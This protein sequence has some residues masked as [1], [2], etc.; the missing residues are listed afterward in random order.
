MCRIQR[1]EFLLREEEANGSTSSSRPPLASQTPDNPA[2]ASVEFE[3]HWRAQELRRLAQEGIPDDPV[4]IRPSTYRRL[5]NLSNTATLASDYSS[6][7]SEVESTISSL[8]P[9]ELHQPLHRYD[10]L[11]REIERDVERTFGALSWF[12]VEPTLTD[13]DEDGRED[14]LW[15]RLRALDEMDTRIAEELS[16]KGVGRGETPIQ[17][18]SDEP[19]TT[20]L[21]S[22]SPPP[23]LTLNIPSSL[24]TTAVDIPP[25]PNTPTA[26]PQSFSSTPSHS[27]RRPS[28]RR[29]ALLRPLFVYAFLNPGVSYVQ[30]MSYLVAVFYYIF[31]SDPT[32]S[33]RQ[34]EATT[35]FAFGSL[36]S[37]L[38]DLY[39]PT[40]DTIGRETSLTHGLG[41]TIERFQGL[42]L[43]LDPTLADTL[44]RK[45]VDLG[46]V[47]LRWLTT[48]FANEFMLPDLVRIW[49][50]IISVYPRDEQQPESLSPMLSHVL[51]LAL[52][53]VI[54][55]RSTFLSPYT[56]LSK[57]YALLQ[58]PSI[59]GSA[60]DK[61]LLLAWDIR[62]RRAGRQSSSTPKPESS[63]PLKRVGSLSQSAGLLKQK[64]WSPASTASRPSQANDFELDTTSSSTTESRLSGRPASRQGGGGGGAFG[65]LAFS[66]PR[67]SAGSLANNVTMIEGKLLPPPPARMEER[68]TIASIVEAELETPEYGLDDDDEDSD[69]RKGTVSSLGGWFKNSMSRIASSDKAAN[70]SKRA[71]NLQLAAA[72]SASTTASRLQSSDAAAQLLKAQ[73]NLAIQAQL[74][75]ERVAAEQFAN[76]V[77]DAGERLMASTGSERG[78][79]DDFG[80][81][82][83]PFTPPVGGMRSPSPSN[84]P[85]GSNAPRPL[86]LSSSARRAHNGSIDDTSD[87]PLS[88]RRSSMAGSV[89]SPSTSPVLSR[90]THL[91]L[92]SPDLSIPPLSRS[93][94]R[95]S[96]GRSTSTFDTPTRTVPASDFRPRS[97]SQSLASALDSSF[98]EDVPIVSTR[99][100]SPATARLVGEEQRSSKEENVS[101]RSG[102]GW[103][104]SDAPRGIVRHEDTK[105]QSLENGLS[106][107]AIEI[108]PTENTDA[109]L[110][111]PRG[112]SLEGNGP[113][114]S[115]FPLNTPARLDESLPIDGPSETP[116]VP[117]SSEPF[118]APPAPSTNSYDNTLPPDS[119]STRRTTSPPPPLPSSQPSLSRGAKI[120]RRPAASKKRSS[121]GSSMAASMDFETSNTM[122][123]DESGIT[124]ESLSRS[125]VPVVE[126]LET[127]GYS[128]SL[129]PRIDQSPFHTNPAV[130]SGTD[131]TGGSRNASDS[132]GEMTTGGQEDPRRRS[133]SGRGKRSDKDTRGTAGQPEADHIAPLKIPVSTTKK[134]S[135]TLDDL[136]DIVKS[137]RLYATSSRTNDEGETRNSRTNRETSTAN[138]NQSENVTPVKRRGPE[139]STPSLSPSP[140]PTSPASSLA[141]S[142]TRRYSSPT[143]R[144]RHATSSASLLSLFIASTAASSLLKTC[145]SLVQLSPTLSLLDLLQLSQSLQE[146]A[147]MLAIAQGQAVASG[148]TFGSSFDTLARLVASPGEGKSRDPS[149]S[150]LLAAKALNL[151]SPSEENALPL[152]RPSTPSPPLLILTTPRTHCRQCQSP[153]TIRSKPN[154]PFSLVSPSEPPRPIL[155]ACHVCTNAACR[156]RHSADHVEITHEKHKVWIWEEEASYTKVGDRVWVSSSFSKHFKALLL[157]QRVSPGGFADVWN[158]QHSQGAN[159]E[160]GLDSE[161]AVGEQ[162]EEDLE[163]ENEPNSTGGVFKLTPAHVW[164]S[165]VIS[166]SLEAAQIRGH[167]LLSTARPSSETL[168]IRQD[169]DSDPQEKITFGVCDGISIGHFLCA[170]PSCSNPPIKQTRSQRF[171]KSHVKSHELCGVIGCNKSISTFPDPRSEACDDP[172]HLAA[173]KMFSEK[174][175]AVTRRGWRGFRPNEKTRDEELSGEEG[176]GTEQYPKSQIKNTWSLRRVAKL[177][178]LVASCGTPLAWCKFGNGETPEAVLRFLTLVHAH[179]G[180]NSSTSFPS[181]IAY[182][183]ACDV[184]REAVLSSTPS[185]FQNPL[186]TPKKRQRNAP[187]PFPSFLES[188]RLVV[189]GFHQQCHTADDEICQ[190]FCNSAPLDGS[191]PDLVIP[192]VSTTASS[193]NKPR[194]FERAFNTSAAEQLNSSLR[195]FT[196]LLQGMK[197]DNFDFLL[198]C[199]LKDKRE[200]LERD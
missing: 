184:L 145:E 22:P 166:S 42:L 199:I 109:I 197:A 95:S 62:E 59:E 157:R 96:H 196:S 142:P 139:P 178:L 25:S 112:S 104:L 147:Q 83:T 85:G 170:F 44:D 117:P 108:A 27:S 90:S 31:A 159:E 194:V 74:L 6:F 105:A 46:G 165:F 141:E 23:T 134:E 65:S 41:A 20:A 76:R 100:G 137:H 79:S 190:R 187:P 70:L 43:W 78:H 118:D 128:L 66:S 103:T 174:R 64:L 168:M 176:E 181:Y 102:K 195:G 30:G 1:F 55:N 91:P 130:R 5:L 17:Q 69:E 48:V 171:C 183:R 67:S 158:I 153:L 72:Q 101:F 36:V 88:S 63:S 186:E 125:D 56:N 164:R 54:T 161:E 198:S 149:S 34:V 106:G 138:S 68:E 15:A 80:P 124:D 122:T 155:V 116:F 173:W 19:T 177:Q 120:V 7:L 33:P 10:Q 28:T 172:E 169:A 151:F 114:P 129:P 189:T 57:L 73:T 24:D 152:P 191:A 81:R 126:R 50:R 86:L 2:R 32:L 9:P 3:E 52:A 60:V 140:T 40:L 29:E 179:L 37:Q 146:N 38:R 8:P 14:A 77:K 16:Q 131:R 127:L 123:G 163:N 39:V 11:L 133:G 162:E 144:R 97:A 94:S 143:K 99:L 150:A 156:A 115:T 49:D 188:S 111:P 175:E 154:G 87:S 193:W 26:A 110:P 84:S 35:F 71:T 167:P 98:D 92:L 148:R 21:P 58:S 61:L 119:S 18:D 89:R 182:D 136:Q 185:T 82:E 135:L 192:Y 51:D 113:L 4:H 75:R 200:K 132:M 47:I 121:R 107:L 13:G 12:S 45:H 93:P 53:I 160:D 180:S